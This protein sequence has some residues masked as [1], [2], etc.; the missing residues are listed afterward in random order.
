MNEQRQYATAV[1]EE[2]LTHPQEPGKETC[3]T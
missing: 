2:W 1:M 3:E